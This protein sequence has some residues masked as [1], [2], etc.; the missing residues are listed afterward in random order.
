MILFCRLVTKKLSKIPLK[1]CN[2]M[3]IM[4][5]SFVNIKSSVQYTLVL[6]RS[7]QTG[8]AHIRGL[9]PVHYSSKAMLQRWQ[10]AGDTL[11]Q[12]GGLA[13]D[14]LGDLTGS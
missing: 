7:M 4:F 10:A 8:K 5:P 11:S 9:V 6:H 1:V 13:L 14:F 3:I 2:C 12:A